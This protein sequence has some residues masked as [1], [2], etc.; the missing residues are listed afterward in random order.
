M[1]EMEYKEFYHTIFD[2]EDYGVVITDLE[3]KILSANLAV[4]QWMNYSQEELAGTDL[5]SWVHPEDILNDPPDVLSLHSGFPVRKERRIKKKNGSWLRAEVVARKMGENRFVIL[6]TDISRS[7]QALEASEESFRRIAETA[8]EGIWQMDASHTT[9]FVNQQMADMLGYTIAEIMGQKVETFLFPKDDEFHRQRMRLRHAGEDELY[10]RRFRKKDGTECWTFASVTAL[11]DSSGTFQGSF[12]LFTD[13][14]GRK[15]DEQ[16]LRNSQEQLQTLINASPDI[17]CFKDD[18][19]RWMLA[20][21]GLLQ[22]YGLKGI[23][24]IGK[25]EFELAE[26]TAPIFREA[27]RNCKGSDDGA[28]ALGSLFRAVE[29]IPD[30]TGRM[31]TFDVV[32]VPLFH[33][34]GSRK[35]LIVY[36]RD[37]TE[38]KATESALRQSEEKYRQIAE[39]TSDVIWMMNTNLKYTYVSPSIFSQRGFTQEEFIQRDIGTIYTPASLEKV[40]QISMEGFQLSESGH[41]SQDYVVSVE[42]QHFCKDGTLRD[43]D[44]RIRPILDHNGKLIGAHGVSRDIT[45]QKLAR[46]KLRMLADFQSKVLNINEFSEMHFLV[47]ETVLNLINDGIVLS[48]NIDNLNKSGKV[49]AYSSIQY[50]AGSIKKLLG[51]SP[52]EISFSLSYY[53]HEAMERFSSGRVE[54]VDGGLN[55][56]LSNLVPEEKIKEIASFLNLPYFYTV[57][58]LHQGLHLGGL[59]IL[60]SS[61]IDKFSDIITV[62]VSQAAVALNRMRAEMALSE[63][64]SRFRLAFSTS[65]DSITINRMDTA[66]FVE[67]NDGFT[68]FTGY[69]RD[70]ALGRSTLE[71]NIW[72]ETKDR[73]KFLETMMTHGKISNMEA[74]F[75]KKSGELT[76]ALM[77]STVFHLHGVPHLFT[78]TRDIEDIKLTQLE[79]IRA[80]EEAEEASRI[81]TAF[82]NN[83]SHEVRT[84]M[85]AI[86]G[87]TELLQSEEFTPAEH[88]RYLGIVQ[89]NANQ[90]L[91]II[92]DVLEVSRLDSGRIPLNKVQ[93][94]LN[95]L[96]EEIQLSMNETVQRKGLHLWYRVDCGDDNDFIVADM[97]KIRQVIHGLIGNAVKFTPDGSISFGCIKRDQETEFF[98][99][100]TGIGIATDD[101]ERI[102]ERFYQVKQAASPGIH[103]TG[104]G[105]S[106]ARGLAEVMLGTIRVESTPAVGSVF[107]LTIPYDKPHFPVTDPDTHLPI[108]LENL[109]ILIAEDENFNYELISILLEKHAKTLIRA[110]NGIEVMAVLRKQKPDLVLMDLKMPVMDGY[111][112]TRRAR[113]MFPDLRI[114][115][116]TAYSQPEDARKAMLAGCNGFV[117]KPIRTQEL[118][119]AITRVLRH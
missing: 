79:L 71:L 29:N 104:L 68:Q 19:G 21:D 113:L 73:D 11:T 62:I 91:S 80:K 102:F 27:F 75:R 3:R 97:E 52:V 10:E 65:P 111:E 85:N 93:F 45:E 26:F 40:K 70:E 8:R 34:D 89:S 53:S 88:E 37:I 25:S 78:I 47:T 51:V 118:F 41:L 50:D 115:A 77:S 99:R 67:V 16:I 117:T 36:G 43:S 96:M 5:M 82:L 81:K 90:L 106:I 56:L 107:Y 7:K 17:I 14:T 48:T 20:N 31:H 55:T 64:E 33:D 108:T 86:I 92:D 13:I 42:L 2:Q 1:D 74:V 6:V 63:S 4:C 95:D 49:I 110:V 58:Y 32:K 39:Y 18:E 12:G 57:G 28:W 100:D 119:D 38:F 98:V 35:G 114:I 87:F 23:D 103:G 9:V 69:T 44:V 109:T 59:M 116:L 112:A 30:T 94:S 61:P 101:K 15:T 83:I 72:N 105:L 22:L 24:Y 60:V 46:E 66:V 54:I 84:P 76:T